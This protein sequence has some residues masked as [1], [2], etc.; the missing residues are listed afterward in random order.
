VAE[1]FSAVELMEE[2]PVVALVDG[3]NGGDGWWWPKAMV[4][5]EECCWEPEKDDFFLT[6]DLKIPLCFCFFPVCFPFSK[7][8]IPPSLFSLLCSVSLIPLWFC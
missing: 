7:K 4:E 8:K 1:R 6:L 5:R 2:R 3:W